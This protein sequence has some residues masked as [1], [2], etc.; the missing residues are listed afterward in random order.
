MMATPDSLSS[1]VL[2]SRPSCEPTVT[3]TWIRPLKIQ[4]TQISLTKDDK[5]KANW[6]KP[7]LKAHALGVA[8]QSEA[9]GLFPLLCAL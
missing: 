4:T 3:G 6:I 5:K 1:T 2:L 9:C 8:K 7:H